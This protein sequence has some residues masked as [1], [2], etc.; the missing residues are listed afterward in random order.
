[1]TRVMAGM[2]TDGEDTCEKEMFHAG[3]YQ[4]CSLMKVMKVRAVSEMVVK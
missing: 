2:R 3:T 4:Q 1:M